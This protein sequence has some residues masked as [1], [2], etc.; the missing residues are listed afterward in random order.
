MYV[1]AFTCKRGICCLK[2]IWTNIYAMMFVK[3]SNQEEYYGVH[4]NKGTKFADGRRDIQEKDKE[5]QVLKKLS[6]I[7]LISNG[8]GALLAFIAISVA[9]AKLSY[10]DVGEF[11]MTMVVGGGM[12]FLFCKWAFEDV[13]KYKDRKKKYELFS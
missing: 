13:R 3:S 6:K 2:I 12:I 7:P 11:M 9:I 8:I 10:F 1:S 4:Q 5:Y